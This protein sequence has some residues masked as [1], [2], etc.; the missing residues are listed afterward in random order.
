[1]NNDRS[2]RFSWLPGDLEPIETP[3][4]EIPINYSAGSRGIN[5]E[6]ESIHDQAFRYFRAGKIPPPELVDRL[7]ELK[8]QGN[9]GTN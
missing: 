7:T 9:N 8:E 1:M 4:T 3:T 2:N 6:I 5:A